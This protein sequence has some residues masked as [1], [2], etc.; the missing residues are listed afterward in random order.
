[1]SAEANTEWLRSTQSRSAG[2][3]L[4]ITVVILVETIGLHLWLRQRHP[5]LA[6]AFTGLSL[7]TLAWLARDYTALGHA[8][9]MLGADGCAIR[10][11][12]RARADLSWSAVE[13][14]RI[15]TWR[16]LPEPAAAYLNAARPDDPNLLLTFRT[17]IDVHTAIGR[18]QVRKLDLRVA[19]PERVVQGWER[20]LTS[21]E[22][23]PGL[24]SG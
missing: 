21:R 13:Q 24:S 1:V 2:V 14:I 10:L 8:G 19:S 5:V 16:D 11:G 6:W 15:P 23:R 12:Y 3:M 7:I 17:P 22:F 4:A 20:W 9:L 18:R